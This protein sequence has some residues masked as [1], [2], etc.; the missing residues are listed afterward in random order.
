MNP[1]FKS[2]ASQVAK[3]LSTLLKLATKMQVLQMNNMG[4]SSI[5]DQE[6]IIVGIA[7][8]RAKKTLKEFSWNDDVSDPEIAKKLLQTLVGYP[9]LEKIYVWNIVKTERERSNWKRT[10]LAVDK[11]LYL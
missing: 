8:S 3:S 6:L 9:R 5:E 11:K 1:V 2:E 10:A 4:I 7:E